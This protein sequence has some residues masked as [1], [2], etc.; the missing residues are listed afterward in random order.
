[1]LSHLN[2]SPQLEDSP[3][4]TFVPFSIASRELQILALPPQ[5]RDSTWLCV[6]LRF[7]ST[8]RIARA[9][10]SASGP[11]GFVPVSLPSL[12]F[13]RKLLPTKREAEED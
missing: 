13:P 10:D 4:V 3:Y 1:M 9:S 2:A 12:S 8:F 7:P 5:K 6:D 11:S